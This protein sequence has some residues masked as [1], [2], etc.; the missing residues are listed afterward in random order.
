MAVPS[1][2]ACCRSTSTT[3]H[4]PI[5]INRSSRFVYAQVMLHFLKR[6]YETL[7]VHRFSNGTMPF[8]YV[9]RKYVAEHVFWRIT[10]VP[11]SSLHYHIFG[12]VF[13]AYAIYRPSYGISSPYIQGTIRD[14]PRFLWACTAVWLVRWHLHD[15]IV[16]LTAPIPVGRI[17]KRDHTYHTSKLT[18]GRYKEACHS[19]RI[20]LRPSILPE[21]HIRNHRMERHVH[22]D[23]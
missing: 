12:G 20:W 9:F 22:Y 23:R 15:I 18:A 6:E 17:V 4:L 3:C 2:I 8:V 14:D 5:N 13:L 7:F 1:N 21:L 16:L 11:P 10:D 19:L